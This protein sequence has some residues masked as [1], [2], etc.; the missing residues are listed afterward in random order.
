MAKT[1][2]G[3]LN[4]SG[5]MLARYMNQMPGSQEYKD[6]LGNP[7]QMDGRNDILWHRVQAF[8]QGWIYDPRLNYMITLWTVNATNQ[9]AI[10]G[11]MSF[12]FN[13]YFNLT[14]GIN[15][16]PGTRS[17]GG[18]HPYWL[19]TDR[20]MADEYFRPGFTSGVWATGE[21]FKNVHYN[22]MVG[23]NLSELGI[24][25]AKLN[26]HLGYGASIWWMPGTGEFGPRGAYGD[27]E[28]HDSLATRMGGSFAH[29][30]ENRY[31]NLSQNSPDNTAIRLSDASLF[32]AGGALA[33]GVT[34]QEA[35]FTQYA[36]D[37]GF[38]Y[39]GGFLQ[40][41]YYFRNLNKFDADGTLP[42]NSIFDHGFMVQAAFF[43]IPKKLEVY[44]ATSQIYGSFNN[45]SECLLGANL[46]PFKTR[47][48]R[49]NG[50]VIAVKDSPVS[51]V[52]GY[53]TGGQTGTTLSIS[54]SI[55][56]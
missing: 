44:G 37:A 42:L 36:I 41:E 54:A 7:Q 39:R 52:F 49:L 19:G 25:A 48:M 53:Y 32:F 35:N 16:F 56:F 34:V 55:L 18:S 15:A 8:I 22:V 50:Q 38:K 33:P 11:S 17:L 28:F 40:F 10:A 1:K 47:N 27:W 29:H 20:V 5:Y 3:V 51:S 21:P 9:V 30:R 2:F 6:H 12:R 43:P 23:D 13:K 31:S 45:A 46:Y 24:S 14:A 26:R 4:I